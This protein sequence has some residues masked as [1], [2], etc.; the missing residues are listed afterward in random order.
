MIKSTIKI[1]VTS[2][3]LGMLIFTSQDAISWSAAFIR[4][5]SSP[6]QKTRRIETVNLADT[7]ML[8]KNNTNVFLDVRAKR[9]HDY[10][11]IPGS[12]NIPFNQLEE[13]SE[14]NLAILKKAPNVVV[15]CIST[16]CGVSYRAARMLMDKGVPN[17]K[18]YTGGWGQWKNCGLPIESK[19]GK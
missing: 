15:Y 11:C 16:S 5:K 12:R 7:I 2:L 17:V 9:Y 3:C 8:H 13:I 4:P 10:A 6:N 19:G 14:A 18:V 1:L